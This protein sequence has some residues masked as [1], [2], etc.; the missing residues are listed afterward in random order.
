MH[1]A[2]NK[3][4]DFRKKFNLKELISIAECRTGPLPTG[5]RNCK[6]Q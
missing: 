1:V 5:N 2:A 4:L 6:V 3:K